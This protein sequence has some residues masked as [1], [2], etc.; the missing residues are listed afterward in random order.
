MKYHNFSVCNE[1]C[2]ESCSGPNNTLGAN[3]CDTCKYKKDI[4]K[5]VT[6]CV[7]ECPATKYDENGQCKGKYN[8]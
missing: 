8:I 1:N 3:G 6:F 7:T 5:D 4:Q 2:L